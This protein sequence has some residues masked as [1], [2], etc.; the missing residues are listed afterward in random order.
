MD[1]VFFIVSV[2]VII[3]IIVW[4]LINRVSKTNDVEKIF[5]RI[6]KLRP[7]TRA[8]TLERRN[9]KFRNV[10][11]DQYGKVQIFEEDYPVAPNGQYIILRDH[12]TIT[13]NDNGFSISG[14]EFVTFKCPV[15]YEGSLCMVQ[16]LCGADDMGK[17]KPITYPQFNGLGLYRNTFERNVVQRQYRAD[18][19]DEPLHKRLRVHCI[20][21]NGHY[22]IEACPPNK[23]L[24]A[25]LQCEP[26]DICTDRLNGFK[27]NFKINEN[28]ADLN[29]DEYYVCENNVSV[30]HTCPEN[31][32]FSMSANGCINR[33]VCYGRGQETI[34]IDD[35]AYIQCKNDTGTR[36][37]CP[38]GVVVD[39]Q[40]V[41]SCRVNICNPE[42]RQFE[43]KHLRYIY[44]ETTC[45]NNVP[46]TITCDATSSDR[47]YNY[48]WAETFEV[49]LENWPKEILKD[50]KCVTPDDSII[51]N[52][53]IELAWSPAMPMQHPFNLKTQQYECNTDTYKY[54][55]DYI[56]QKL[57]P[58]L[59]EWDEFVYSGAPCQ[60]AIA[61]PFRF[62]EQSFPNNKI[63]IIKTQP[64]HLPNYR[65]ISMWP[66]VRKNVYY[67]TRCEFTS[68][69]LVVT[70]YSSQTIP[71]GFIEQPDSIF[72]LL[73]G[74]KNFARRR[75]V[76]Y[77]F[78]VS[79]KLDLVTMH[80]PT[81]ETQT[82]YR[83]P[84]NN[85]VDTKI[86]DI[87]T[88][89]VCINMSN[90]RNTVTIN[91]LESAGNKTVTFDPTSM[92]VT[93]GTTTY[94][95]G[96]SVFTL[97]GLETANHTNFKFGAID[98]DF[99]NEKLPQL[100]F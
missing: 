83:Y 42:V 88:K 10:K 61:Q 34:A 91:Q 98:I 20:D 46:Q 74:Y 69:G 6:S 75:N 94:N 53:I 60:N 11:S 3:L 39:D 72:L 8:F 89:T 86:D 41:R 57:E 80:N 50:G 70:T 1:I 9:G 73:S 15:G 19:E 85:A 97:R 84:E 14:M 59:S 35:T 40:N 99:D 26:Y 66:T 93:D 24:N 17:I 44:S 65:N 2:I 5:Q 76:Q 21:T 49:R 13:E 79:G 87:D 54:R 82:T 95:L 43:N 32:A 63:Y 52:P 100:Q 56:G 51:Y 45:T 48:E 78:I 18:G 12:G 29:N 28:D 30:K 81:V 64:V 22:E 71:L 77:Y 27:H 23:L 47:I 16:P 36:V 33:S 31:T 25:N 62:H 55:W 7:S 96:F 4:Y 92:T 37:N 68:D 58:S 90:F 67:H 38:D